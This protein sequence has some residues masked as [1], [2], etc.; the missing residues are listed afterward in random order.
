MKSL[1]Y[2][3]LYYPSFFVQ[4]RVTPILSRKV[5]IMFNVKNKIE[6]QSQSVEDTQALGEN[7]GFF[8]QSITTP[9]CIAIVGD[10]GT[11][12]THLS[13]GIAIGFGITEEV[14]SP[15]F[16]IMNTYGAINHR[17]YHFD[18]YRLTTVEELDTIGFYEYTEE[19]KSIVEW[20]DMFQDELPDTTLWVQIERIS[21]TERRI[22]LASNIV[23]SQQLSTIGG[24]IC[25]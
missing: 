11:G 2:N 12:K 21:E 20:A 17:L 3:N 15:T 24:R 9:L 7:I 14:T 22:T 18:L 1:I 19:Q 6:C 23:D 8:L 5:V 25:I 4:V 13:K 10:L 16:S